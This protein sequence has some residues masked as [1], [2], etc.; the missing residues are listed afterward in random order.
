MQVTRYMIRRGWQLDGQYLAATIHEPRTPLRVNAARFL[1][2]YPQMCDLP[3]S[4]KLVNMVI[5]G[6]SARDHTGANLDQDF[7]AAREKS[8]PGTPSLAL[9][10]TPNLTLFPTPT[11]IPSSTLTLT[12]TRHA[13]LRDAVPS[14]A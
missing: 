14:L 7:W 9:T 12:L 2:K 5:Y 1:H 11:P 6:E 3:E 10:I 8:C 13:Q 4:Q